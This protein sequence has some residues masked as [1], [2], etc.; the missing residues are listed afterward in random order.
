[1]NKLI[2]KM[3]TIIKIKNSIDRC[4]LT[5]M[6]IKQT[7]VKDISNEYQ[8]WNVLWQLELNSYLYIC[9]S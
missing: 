3:I 2:H 9:I 8:K 7:Q 5:L 6:R 4:L 1:M